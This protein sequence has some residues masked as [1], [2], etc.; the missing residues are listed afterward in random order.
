MDRDFTHL[1]PDAVE[2]PLLV[3]YFSYTSN[4]VSWTTTRYSVLLAWGGKDAKGNVGKTVYISYDNGIR[5]RQA[6]DLLQLPA[7]IPATYD[8]QAIVM[9]SVLTASRSADA[10]WEPMPSLRIPAWLMVET[11]G[12]MMSRATTPIT[13]WECPYVYIFGGRDASATTQNTIWRGVIN[14]LT[15]KPLQ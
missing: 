8:A 13:E 2:S 14:R 10:G 15:F 3:P 4:N 7:Y 1:L 12:D 11:A 6:D 5:W 9:P